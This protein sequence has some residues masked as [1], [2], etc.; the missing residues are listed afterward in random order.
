MLYCP[1]RD[2]RGA[3]RVVARR[4]LVLGRRKVERRTVPRRD[5]ALRRRRLAIVCGPSDRDAGAALVPGY[6]TAATTAAAAAAAASACVGGLGRGC[7]SP[8]PSA[9]T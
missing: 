7:P 9:A 8:A 6:P 1:R 2:E 4:Q 3:D 5:V